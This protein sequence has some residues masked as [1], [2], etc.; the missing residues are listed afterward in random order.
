[1]GLTGACG[2]DG[3]LERGELG[4]DESGVEGLRDGSAV[5]KP[6]PEG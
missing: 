3:A 6:E 2:L 5:L 1:M 4:A